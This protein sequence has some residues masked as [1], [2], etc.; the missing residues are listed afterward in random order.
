[1][2]SGYVFKGLFK[3]KWVFYLLLLAKNILVML[4]RHSVFALQEVLRYQSV[5]N[6]LIHD[7]LVVILRPPIAI[8]AVAVL[9]LPILLLN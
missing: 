7:L 1:V 5:G 3:R 2:V 8:S 4:R 6:A 9:I